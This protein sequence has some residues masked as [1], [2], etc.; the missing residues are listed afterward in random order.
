MAPNDWDPDSES[1]YLALYR[2]FIVQDDDDANLP[3]ALSL[4]QGAVS[5]SVI[6]CFNA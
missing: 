2:E 1:R 3:G 5:P 6:S 4:N